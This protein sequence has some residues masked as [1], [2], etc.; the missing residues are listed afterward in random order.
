MAS[1]TIVTETLQVVVFSLLHSDSKI[2]EDYGVSIEQVREIRAL[3]SITRVPKAPAYVKGVMNL[4]G[5]IISVIDVKE[6]LGFGSGGETNG[7]SRIL[8]ADTGTLTG[9]LVDEVDQ[10][11]RIPTKDVEP[12][13]AGSSESSYIKGIAK[14]QGKLIILLDLEKLLEG[15][16]IEQKV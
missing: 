3:E 2:K 7:K 15:S 1:E 4:R 10:V 16:D 14:T 12:S 6:K 11:I 5:K 9:L 8:I 13:P